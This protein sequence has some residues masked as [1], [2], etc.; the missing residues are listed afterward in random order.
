MACEHGRTKT[1][2]RPSEYNYA[3]EWKR[4]SKTARSVNEMNGW[5]VWVRV[6]FLHVC[7]L[8]PNKLNW[9]WNIEREKNQPVHTEHSQNV[10]S[11]IPQSTYIKAISGWWEHRET[12]T[13]K[14]ET[15]YMYNNT[16]TYIYIA[17]GKRSYEWYS[18]EEKSLHQTY[19]RTLA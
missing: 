17:Y 18:V 16:H 15:L 8:V 7:L 6:Y 9:E 5:V 1:I 3:I 12:E 4:H 2:M 11:H 10:H 14:R 19:N 13:L